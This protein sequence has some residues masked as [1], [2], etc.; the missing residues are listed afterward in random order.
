MSKEDHRP[1]IVL[2]TAN[3][4]PHCV[5]YHEKWPAIKAK[6]NE[7]GAYRVIENNLKSRM[8]KP[9]SSKVPMAITSF[10]PHFPS[11]ALFE[12]IRWNKAM[13]DKNSKL[14]GVICPVDIGN[15]PLLL[16]W[17]EVESGKFKTITPL[18]VSSV[19][20][21]FS[22]GNPAPRLLASCSGLKLCPKVVPSRK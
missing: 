12:G 1:V 8:D 20:K 10:I 9:D 15:V 22:S 2:T 18:V 14:T 4:C 3:D 7:S 6:I 5:K 21:D 19:D 13:R 16:K 17:L 11:I